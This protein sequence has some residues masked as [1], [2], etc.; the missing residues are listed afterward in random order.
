[1][2]YPR[3]AAFSAGAPS[4]PR[5]RKQQP[6]HPAEVG[7]GQGAAGGRAPLPPPHEGAAALAQLEVRGA[8]GP[9]AASRR[10]TC[11]PSSGP[12]RRP[13]GTSGAPPAA[14]APR[15][16]RGAR[17]RPCPRGGAGT[18]GRLGARLPAPAATPT[19]ASGG[20]EEGGGCRG[21]GG[22]G[23]SRGG[24][25]RA[26]TPGTRRVTCCSRRATFED[27]SAPA[28]KSPPSM[29]ACVRRSP[30]HASGQ[31]QQRGL[32]LVYTGVCTQLTAVQ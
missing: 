30:G 19:T 13:G 1:M 18:P 32:R 6:P 25:A 12:P 4:A 31:P 17:P 22:S 11:A 27:A 29:R 7:A 16:L 23:L 26:G 2:P 15:T 24:G 20:P 28:R 14:G 10:A 21:G 9:A 3:P 8:L 5:G